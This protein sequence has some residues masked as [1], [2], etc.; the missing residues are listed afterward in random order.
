MTLVILW[1]FISAHR[2][3]KGPVIN[4][5]HH[6]IGREDGIIEGL[7]HSSDSDSP[8]SLPSKKAELEGSTLPTMEIH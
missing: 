2:W 1:W 5:E 4:V 3:F 7:E 8:Q 6:M